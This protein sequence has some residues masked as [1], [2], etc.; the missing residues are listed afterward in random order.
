MRSLWLILALACSAA[1][2]NG[3]ARGV[4]LTVA[5]AGGDALPPGN[6]TLNNLVTALKNYGNPNV[7]LYA[8]SFLETTFGLHA[9]LAYDPAY[10]VPAVQA[11]CTNGQRGARR[12]ASAR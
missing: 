11:A 1:L 10:S 12:L 5:S 4:F 6:L 9:D 8:Q 7:P 2:P 3:A